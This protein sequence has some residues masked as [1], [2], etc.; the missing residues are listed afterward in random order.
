[1]SEKRFLSDISESIDVGWMI[2]KSNILFFVGLTVGAMVLNVT[3]STFVEKAIKN[4]TVSGVVGFF[5]GI[6]FNMGFTQVFLN[7]VSAEKEPEISD[8]VSCLPLFLAYLGGT[9]LFMLAVMAPALL[10][11]PGVIFGNNF[12]AVVGGVLCVLFSINFGLK[13]C[14]FGFF[15]IDQEMGPIEA[16]RESAEVTEGIKWDL[17]GL[18]FALSCV[19]L[20]GF[21][22]IGLG[23]F[24]AYPV[25]GIAF[26]YAYRN[27]IA[28][29]IPVLATPVQPL[30]PT[31]GA[32]PY[33]EPRATEPT[34]APL[35]KPM[36][37]AAEDE[38]TIYG[39]PKVPLG[40]ATEAPQQPQQPMG[41]PEAKP[42]APEG[43][44]PPTGPILN[45][46]KK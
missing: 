7:A 23:F 9:V 28:V 29:P 1:M 6:V 22:A 46:R 38:T 18:L 34:S 16:L 40:Q 45:A 26:A 37:G 14:L 4:P 42:A 39:T 12:F 27:L 44:K 33:G 20:L 15:V 30:P 24:V 32:T 35:Q 17:I 21:M 5:I 41:A 2:V 19:S 10:I 36:G 13:Y 43:P 31:G 3:L 8:F 11:L 25:V